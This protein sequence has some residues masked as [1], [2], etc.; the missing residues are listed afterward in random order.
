MFAENGWRPAGR[1]SWAAMRHAR[2]ARLRVSGRFILMQ[3]RHSGTAKR[4][5]ESLRCRLERL[6]PEGHE[7]FAGGEEFGGVQPG[8]A[9]DDAEHDHIDVQSGVRCATLPD[10]QLPVGQ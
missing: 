6:F 4:R 10:G 9:G 1:S 7:I 2:V 3:I 8:G 5:Q